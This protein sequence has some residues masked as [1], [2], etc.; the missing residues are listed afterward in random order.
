MRKHGKLNVIIV[1]YLQLMRTNKSENRTNEVSEISRSLKAIAKEMNCPVIALSQLNRSLET[2]ADKRP[3][4]SDLRDSGAIE[5]D[6]DIIW[7]LYRD[8]VYNENTDRKGVAELIT[9][10]FR[11][12]ETG[13][14]F[15][16][17][18]LGHSK[19]KNLFGEKPREPE[20]EPRKEAPFKQYQKTKRASS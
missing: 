20:P 17:S 19:F 9:A 14:D 16:N 6:A 13:I 3:M 8:E 11:N 4:M 2:R 12:G 15:L 5:Q 18:D 10:K 7:F 1:D